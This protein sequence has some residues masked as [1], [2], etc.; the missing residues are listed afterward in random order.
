MRHDTS[1]SR[2]ATLKGAAALALGAATRAAHA[3][4][5]LEGTLR[6][7]VGY[8]PGGTSDRAARLIGEALQARLGI[9]VIVENKAGA[10]GRLAAQQLRQ[11]SASE[12]VLML[13]NPAVMTVA[14]LVFKD[15]GYD[16]EA[17]FA[18]VAMAT[19]YEFAVAVGP[20]V[21][22]REVTHLLAWLRA[23]P[24][25]AFF[26]VPATGS[27]P[28]FFALMLAE[29]ARI[30]AD[31]VGYKGSAP[32]SVG[33]VGGEIPVA[34][35]TLDALLPLHQRGR[36]RILA[37]SGKARSPFSPEI[38]T[39]R[40]AGIELAAIGWNAFF[41]PRAMPPERAQRLAEAIRAVTAEPALRKRFADA[42]MELVSMGQRDTAELVRAY[43]AQWAP[44]V[45]RSGYE[46]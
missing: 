22:V 38:P 46:P 45:Q 13:A 25:K 23:N 39:L 40:E 15:A 41:A 10:G 4:P 35:D 42:S 3:Q 33:L 21:P 19:T 36:L 24:E 12:L 34:I 20:Q 27:L 32:L 28:H 31:V 5:R 29:R 6:L 7:V 8:P 2:R 14:P 9:P 16:P 17:D 30:R 37:T 44:V 11:A 26:G 18:P 43:K 1:R